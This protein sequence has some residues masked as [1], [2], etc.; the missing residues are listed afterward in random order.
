MSDLIV[1]LDYFRQALENPIFLG[2]DIDI[3]FQTT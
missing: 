1:G 2:N 3:Y